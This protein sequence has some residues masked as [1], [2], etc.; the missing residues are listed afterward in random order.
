MVNALNPIP[1]SI[2]FQCTHRHSE[3]PQSI[4]I[5]FLM[6]AE[7]TVYDSVYHNAVKNMLGVESS[8]PW[9]VYC[10]CVLHTAPP[11]IKRVVVWDLKSF[12]IQGGMSQGC[13]IMGGDYS[14]L[15]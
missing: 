10:C 2:L 12:T 1:G 15:K 3:C 5:F 13:D 7:P 6:Y 14:G 11:A 4:S 9:V 8:S